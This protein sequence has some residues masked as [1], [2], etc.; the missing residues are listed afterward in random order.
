[1]FKSE[2]TNDCNYMNL[3]KM[4]MQPYMDVPTLFCLHIW[5][6]CIYLH[7]TDQYLTWN[8]FTVLSQCNWGDSTIN[9]NSLWGAGVGWG[10]MDFYFVTQSSVQRFSFSQL[11]CGWVRP[12][13]RVSSQWAPARWWQDW[14]TGSALFGRRTGLCLQPGWFTT[15]VPNCKGDV[16]HWNFLWLHNGQSRS[17]LC[18]S[19]S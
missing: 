17:L 11:A 15:Q 16:D 1:M 14:L 13:D 3:E 19:M 12:W 5:K 4:W 6:H 18:Q 9:T 2:P 10:E 7:L 8:W